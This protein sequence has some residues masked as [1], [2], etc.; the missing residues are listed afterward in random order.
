MEKDDKAFIWVVGCV[1]ACLFLL[2][3]F[4]G[5][6]YMAALWAVAFGG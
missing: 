2:G 4:E 1:M 5:F 6:L 3:M